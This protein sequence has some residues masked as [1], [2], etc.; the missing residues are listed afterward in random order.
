MTVEDVGMYQ[1]IGSALG[2]GNQFVVQSSAYLSV[3]SGAKIIVDKKN[4]LRNAGERIRVRYVG[5]GQPAGVDIWIRCSMSVIVKLDSLRP[6]STD[7]STVLI[8]FNSDIP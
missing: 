6:T 1:C 5:V 3:R 7:L 8:I 4:M 2:S